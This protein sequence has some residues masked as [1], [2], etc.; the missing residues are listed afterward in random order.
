M[1]K[2]VQ[3]EEVVMFQSN[4]LNLY[5]LIYQLMFWPLEQIFT[6]TLILHYLYTA[7]FLL[8]TF[9]FRGNIL[10]YLKVILLWV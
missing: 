5:D 8:R 6:R 3:W 2:G 7:S 1:V 4:H 10:I 9:G